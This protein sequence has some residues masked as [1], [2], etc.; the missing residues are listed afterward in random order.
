MT[1]T[2]QGKVA[3]I[4]GAGSGIGRASAQKFAQDGASVV[5]ADINEQGGNKTVDLI[6]QAGGTAIFVQT[7]VSRGKDVEALV[8]QTIATYGRLDVAHNNAGI[9]G[10]PTPIASMSEERFDQTLA[11]NL[12]G[13]WLC[14]KYEIAQML[15]Q[16]GGGAI[17]NTSSAAGL[18]ALPGLTDYIASKHGIV[19][20]TKG[21][22]LEYA[23][24]GIRV[25]AI[26]PGLINT[27]MLG[28]DT[29]KAPDPALIAQLLQAQPIGRLGTAQEIAN[30]AVWLCSDEASFI[31]GAAIPVDG[32][33]VAQ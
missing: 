28:L 22:A 9:S 25:N 6:R 2:F 8:R 11:I 26:C 32:G 16:N 12:K 17:V 3:L 29:G 27:P 23:T 18:I 13:V 14:M 10:L 5:V 7:D 15:R 21:A 4:T 1:S 31:T 33:G 24:A 19:G 20:I 30:A